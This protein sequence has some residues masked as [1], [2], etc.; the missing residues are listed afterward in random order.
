[1]SKRVDLSL[2]LIAA[3]CILTAGPATAGSRSN[4]MSVDPFAGATRDADPS[5]ANLAAAEEAPKPIE[6][7][8]YQIANVGDDQS[9][10]LGGIVSEIRLGVLKH[11]LGPF[12]SSEESGT[13]FNFEVLFVSPKFLDFVWA[14]RPHLG[15]SI[16]SGDDTDQAYFGL[17]WEFD[18]WRNIFAALSFGGSF[19][20]YSVYTHTH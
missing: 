11:D 20:A 16:N 8:E 9:K 4:D 19:L 1:M 13:D 14:P 18:V 2:I 12:S 10:A 5:S 3:M 15:V 7:R 6:T 17:S